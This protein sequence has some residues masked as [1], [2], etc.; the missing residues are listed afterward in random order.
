MTVGRC[1]VVLTCDTR[2]NKVADEN[3]IA[4]DIEVLAHAL[5]GLLDPFL[6]S[7]MG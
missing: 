2:M 6:T 4:W 3:S 7:R 5:K 1:L